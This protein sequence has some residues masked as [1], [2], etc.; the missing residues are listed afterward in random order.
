MDILPAIDLRGGK[1]VRLA[2]GDYDLQ[3]TYHDDP[4][5]VARQFIAAGAKW[6]HMVD[7]DAARSGRPA[8]HQAVRAVAEASGAAIQLGGGARDEATVDAMLSLGIRRVV[9][10]SAAM[11]DWPWFERLAAR[12]DLAGRLALGLDARDGRLAAEGWTEQLATTALELARR[13]RGWPLGAIVYTDIGRDGMLSGVNVEATAEIV[14][15]TDVPVIA[16]GGL[17]D[18]ADVAE[19]R[20]IGCAGAIIGRA[21]YEGSIDLARAVEVAAEH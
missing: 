20:R 12:D 6:I 7:L 2:R 11:K 4:V 8:N 21:Y 13:V 16:S 3:T 17:R 1:V 14:A 9:V 15:A 18:L 19:C 5:E 10:G